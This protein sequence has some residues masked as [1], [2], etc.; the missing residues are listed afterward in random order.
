MAASIKKNFLLNS[1]YQIL[2]ILTPLVTTPYL[3]RV[4]GPENV[5]VYS[6][7]SSITNYFVMF[8]LLG[9]STYGVRAIAV[10]TTREERSK[11]F[12]SAYAS[13]LIMGCAVLIA[14]AVYGLFVH[15][16]GYLITVLWGMWVLS[17]ALNVSW[18]LFGLEEFKVTTI[19]SCIVRLLSVA[20]IFLF[21]RDAG[22][23]WGYVAAISGAYLL[24]QLAVWPFVFKYVDFHKPSFEELKVHFIP[25][26]KLFI[27]VIAISLYTSLDKII[28]GA[29]SDM[30]QAG[31]FEYSEKLSKMPL[32][33]IT[34]MGTVMLPRMSSTLASG[35]RAEGLNLIQKSMWVMQAGAMALAFGIAAI[36]PEFVPVFFGEGY[37]PCIP[38]MV[39]ISITIPLIAATNVIGKQYLLPTMR[40]NLYTWSVVVGAVVNLVINFALIP[41]LGA[42]GAAIATVAA[43]LVVLLA[44]SFFV[45]KELPLLSYLRDAIP[46]AVIG[47]VML[48]A[49]RAS[50]AVFNRIWGLSIYGLAL[51][52]VVGVIVFVALTLIML[53]VTRSEILQVAKEMLN[54]RRI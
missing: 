19:R 49:V 34:A 38:L 31:Y 40:E 32:A 15:A 45:R 23:L 41:S 10:C 6:Y 24:E 2:Q 48:V 33:V 8:A 18:L 53:H 11:T 36:T 28:L 30:R 20:A 52:I 44:Q 27:P 51:E 54:N 3:S 12:W 50:A 13:Q 7:T 16:G 4:L 5:G 17:A 21:V 22:D 46:F 47:A 25:N 39:I 9:M 29:M 37:D 43:E 14:Y 42:M 1:S 35:D 26:L